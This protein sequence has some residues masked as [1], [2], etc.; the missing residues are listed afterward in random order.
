MSVRPRIQRTF[1]QWL[2][3]HKDRL[4]CR[5]IPVSR[6][7]YLLEMKLQWGYSHL[8]FGLGRNEID[9]SVN[10]QGQCWDIIFNEIAIPLAVR[11]GY[12]C[13]VC[14]PSERTLFSSREELWKEHLFEPFAAWIL[15][16]L[17]NANAI[18]LHQD[19]LDG[20]TWAKLTSSEVELDSTI[21]A[22]INLH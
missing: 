20:S 15:K 8:T 2:E 6:S 17:A 16:E 14:R 12:V 11:N 3:E 18:V 19:R 7:D 21:R 1:V 5:L 13:S 22:T 9:V 4:P 10:W